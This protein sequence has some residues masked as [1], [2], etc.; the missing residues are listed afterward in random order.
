MT[1]SKVCPKCNNGFSY[2]FV[3]R[4]YPDKRMYCDPCKA[5]NDAAYA[6]KNNPQVPTEQNG[7]VN[8]PV[9][10]IP[11]TGNEVVPEIGTFQK[12]VWNHEV[13]ANVYKW[14]I[15]P[16]AG[17]PYWY[18]EVKYETLEQLRELVEGRKDIKFE[19]TFPQE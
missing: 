4:G 14:G 2:E 3:N 19:D 15:M 6:A 5:V 9:Q 8:A 18:H 13:A 16:K 11:A 17:Q 10:K 7:P 1:I 12:T